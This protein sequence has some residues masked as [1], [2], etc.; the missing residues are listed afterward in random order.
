MKNKAFSFSAF[1]A[2]VLVPALALAQNFTYANNWIDQGLK[3]LRLSIT[4]VMIV[5][6][7]YFLLAVF[8]FIRE[9]EPAKIKDRRQTVING[10]IG[11]FLAVSVWGIIRIAGQVFGTE[12]NTGPVPIACPPGLKFNPVTGVCGV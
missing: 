10:L 8:Q 7:L 11:L 2:T 9:K 4:V 12:S 1:A 5:M 6:T 3:W